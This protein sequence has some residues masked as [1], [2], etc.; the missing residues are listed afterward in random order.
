MNQEDVVYMYSVVYHKALKNN[1]QFLVAWVELENAMFNKV[2]Q[3]M[4]SR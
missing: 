2:I 3:E 1:M 4:N